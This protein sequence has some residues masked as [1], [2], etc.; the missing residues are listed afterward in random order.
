MNSFHGSPFWLSRLI[1]NAELAGQRL[2]NSGA[3]WMA[4]GAWARSIRR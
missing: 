3:D 1:M 2:A 4:G